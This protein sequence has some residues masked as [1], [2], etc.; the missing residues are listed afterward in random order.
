V[1]V[2]RELIEVCEPGLRAH[3]VSDPQPGRF[4]TQ[5]HDRRRAFVFEA[6]YEG[7]L[8]HYSSPRVF[9]DVD[10]DMRLLA[11]DS[12]YA[13]AVSRLAE[14]GDLDAVA[15]LAALISLCASAHAQGKPE[16][17]DELW[18]ASLK[19]LSVG[20]PSVRERAAGIYD[21]QDRSCDVTT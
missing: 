5:F 4:E 16:I 7:Y 17:I 14:N 3:A 2:L 18:N 11:G 1:T 19:A 9:V 21:G 10:A 6:T 15:E 20:A 12:L 8:M 13:L